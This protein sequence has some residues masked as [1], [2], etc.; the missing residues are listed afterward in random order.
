ML[1]VYFGIY[2]KYYFNNY[3]YA[4]FIIDY[5]CVLPFG[6][7]KKYVKIDKVVAFFDDSVPP[8]GNIPPL[9]AIISAHL[10]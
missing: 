2:L 1:C 5:E 7:M 6:I 9:T 8:H 3:G 4:S 10:V